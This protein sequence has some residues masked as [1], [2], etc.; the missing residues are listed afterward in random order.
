MVDMSNESLISYL[1]FIHLFYHY[2]VHEGRHTRTSDCMTELEKYKTSSYVYFKI[3]ESKTQAICRFLTSLNFRNVNPFSVN[4]K[5]MSQY[6]EY[7]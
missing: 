3:D 5:G 2:N 4:M 7:T 1:M 6:S